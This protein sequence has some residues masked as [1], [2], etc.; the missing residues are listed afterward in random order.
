MDN[1]T[2]AHLNT[3][4]EICNIGAS[5]AATSLSIM[6][7]EAVNM[8]L[9]AASVI[10]FDELSDKLGGAETLSCCVF[11]DISGE[12]NAIIMIL[13]SENFSNIVIDALLGNCCKS[14]YKMDDMSLSVIK[15]LGN[16]LAGSYMNSISQLANLKVKMSTPNI[17]ID[18]TGAILNYPMLR[19]GEVNNKILFIEDRFKITDNDIQSHI[20]LFTE[21]K[22]LNLLFGKLGLYK[23]D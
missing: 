22:S 4:Q 13:L 6:L 11:L 10:K 9:P 3:L 7:N 18:M 21:E 5:N 1:L 23:D 19:F 17:S 15:E 8:H 12:I 16:I 2:D 20:L 14:L